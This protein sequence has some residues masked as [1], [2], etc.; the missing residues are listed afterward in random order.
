M[1][2]LAGEVSDGLIIAEPVT[3]RYTDEV[4]LPALDRGLARVTVAAPT[5]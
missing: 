3:K 2:E 4:M 5:S 1:C